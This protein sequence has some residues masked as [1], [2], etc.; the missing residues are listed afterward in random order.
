MKVRHF[1]GHLDPIYGGPTYS[2]PI[3]CI[4]C[5]KEG[6]EMSFVTFEDSSPWSPEEDIDNVFVKESSNNI[7]IDDEI[8]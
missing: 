7:I 8:W 5:Q 4:N 3:Q 6:A 1:L 2:V